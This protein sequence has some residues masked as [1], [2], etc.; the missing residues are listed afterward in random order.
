MD[1]Y[2]NY[3]ERERVCVCV[4]VLRLDTLTTPAHARME[5]MDCAIHSFSKGLVDSQCWPSG[6]HHGISVSLAELRQSAQVKGLAEWTP[7]ITK[8]METQG[9]A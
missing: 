8:E 5:E 2:C 9:L 1:I 3:K 7:T 6:T 4:C